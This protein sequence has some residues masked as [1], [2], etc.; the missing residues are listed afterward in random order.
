MAAL[1]AVWSHAE[2]MLE[3]KEHDQVE[4]ARLANR[5]LCQTSE[6]VP[7][8]WQHSLVVQCAVQVD[9]LVLHDQKKTLLAIGEVRRAE[10]KRWPEK[11]G[12]CIA[13]MATE[14]PMSVSAE[15]VRRGHLHDVQRV[16]DDLWRIV[17][18]SNRSEVVPDSGPPR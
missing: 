15:H 10:L 14:P 18:L 11:D 2:H 3:E 1:D 8:L 13:F 12:V 16:A 4:Y 9:L 6:H 17:A 7:A 5:V